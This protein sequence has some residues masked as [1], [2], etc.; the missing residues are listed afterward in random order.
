MNFGPWMQPGAFGKKLEYIHSI[1]AV[2]SFL[3]GS[4]YA[5]IKIFESSNSMR[6]FI[7]GMLSYNRLFRPPFH[8][9]VVSQMARAGAMCLH[10][11][12][13]GHIDI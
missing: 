13:L 10:K 7:A 1:P 2:E 11:S 9:L 6:A 8:H 12:R 4:D 3:E 5:D